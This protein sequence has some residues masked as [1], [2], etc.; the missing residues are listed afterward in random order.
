[1]ETRVPRRFATK[2]F[3][4]VVRRM[5]VNWSGHAHGRVG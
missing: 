4:R 5:Q 1:L 2:E 3:S